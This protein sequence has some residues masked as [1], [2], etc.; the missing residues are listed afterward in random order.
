MFG[1][2]GMLDL[3]DVDLVN[4]VQ[5]EVTKFPMEELEFGCNS[6]VFIFPPLSTSTGCDT[7]L[8]LVILY[9]YFHDYQ[10]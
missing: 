2:A 10:Y 9:S 1:Y 3:V 6:S 7:A 5:R 4:M 8:G